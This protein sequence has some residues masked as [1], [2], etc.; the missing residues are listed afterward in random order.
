MTR[1]RVHVHGAA[2]KMGSTCVDAVGQAADMELVGA[3]GR[4]D[5]LARCLARTQPEVVVEFTVVAAVEAN[6]RAALDAGAHVVSGTTGLAPER[7]RALGELAVRELHHERKR[8]AP[9][10][11]ALHTARLIA[12]AAPG[13]LN[14]ARPEA[15]EARAGC[16]GAVE[17]G[18]PIHSIRLPG[19]LAHQE[20]IFGG[21][22]QL[23]TLRH[24]TLDRRAFVPGVLVAIRRIRGRTGLLDS[25]EPLLFG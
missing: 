14:P 2:G 13:T 21:P 7:A 4:G 20:V 19:L 10:G 9:S 23:L 17:A 16:R 22:G 11:T 5:D 3:T 1:I 6:L 18:V 12:A 8:D 25:L 24:D 15:E